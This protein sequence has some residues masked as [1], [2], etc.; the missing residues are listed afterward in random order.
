MI[1]GYDCK[2]TQGN[3]V[4]KENMHNKKEILYF[5]INI[6]LHTLNHGNL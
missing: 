2:L 1:E 6:W 3:N 4:I 5:L